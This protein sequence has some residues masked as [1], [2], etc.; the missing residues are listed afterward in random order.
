MEEV[1]AT[2]FMEC[3]VQGE[4]HIGADWFLFMMNKLFKLQPAY[5]IPPSRTFS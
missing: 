1:S 2:C 3:F 5:Y 4:Y